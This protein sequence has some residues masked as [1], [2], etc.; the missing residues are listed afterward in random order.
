MIRVLVTTATLLF[1]AIAFADKPIHP[2]VE[3]SAEMS[4]VDNLQLQLSH[5]LAEVGSLKA[6]LIACQLEKKYEI[7]PGDEFNS[8]T[9]KIRHKFQKVGVPAPEAQ[10]SFKTGGTELKS[11]PSPAPPKK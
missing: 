8:Q 1:A 9:R 6:E 7:K 4:E 10:K 11:V 3:T 5:A 2:P